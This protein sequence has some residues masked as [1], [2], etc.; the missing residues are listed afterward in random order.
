MNRI[1]KSS[2]VLLIALIIAASIFTIVVIRAYVLPKS[3]VV[4]NDYPFI[5]TAIDHANAGDTVT[6]KKGTYQLTAPVEISKPLSLIGEEPQT[7]IVDGNGHN[8]S[9][10]AANLM[11]F[12]IGAPDVT[13][14]GFTITDCN[15]AIRV[16]NFAKQS[17]PSN[18]K[19]VG[20]I[21]TN[22][23][24]AIDIQR[25]ENFEIKDNTINNNEGGIYISSNGMASTGVIS[26]NTV[27][28][29]GQGISIYSQSVTV[30][31]NRIT[32]NREG[33]NL[34]WTGPYSIFDNT[35]LNNSLYGVIFGPGVSNTLFH[36]N[37]VDRNTIGINLENFVV[38]GDAYI[39]SGNVVYS[40]NLIDNGQNAFVEKSYL[41]KSP[42]SV[43]GTDIVS[44]DNGKDG[45]YWSD[46]SGNGT[47]VIDQNNIDHH[48][49]IFPAFIGTM[50]FYLI[51]ITVVVLFA[52]ITFLLL[53]R[54]HRKTAKEIR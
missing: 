20:N 48:P 28:Q 19:I 29:N 53:Y 25:S 23:Y 9:A 30:S 14:S 17:A 11:T 13:I 8:P 24:Q 12:Q 34:E 37:E 43:N 54:K 31:D 47:Y 2:A 16:E 26:G 1:S 40:N 42:N 27:T 7:T 3:I 22:N 35:I 36:N 51:I 52:I 49:L 44:W 15:F 50:A 18:C 41:Y 21:F 38:S 10:S 4:P 6:V 39:G 45:N 32:N 5:Q 46:Y 33:L